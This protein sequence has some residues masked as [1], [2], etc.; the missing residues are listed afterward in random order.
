MLWPASSRPED[1]A[2]A[3]SPISPG[4]SV[5]DQFTGPPEAVSV[6]V[7]PVSGLSTIVLGA[8]LSVPGGGG[9]VLL[10]DG[11]GEPEDGL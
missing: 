6:K 2:T 10:A 1:G 5:M 11:V 7:P 3:S 8:T 9:A 4:D